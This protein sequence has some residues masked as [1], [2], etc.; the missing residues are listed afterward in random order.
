MDTFCTT[1]SQLL[2]S[3]LYHLTIASSVSRGQTLL[4]PVLHKRPADGK[5]L[6]VSLYRS[7]AGFQWQLLVDIVLSWQSVGS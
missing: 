3:P 2:N 1:R 6:G 5:G 4:L 7:H